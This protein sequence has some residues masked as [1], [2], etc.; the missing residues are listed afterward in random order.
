LEIGNV[1]PSFQKRTVDIDLE[2]I[3][4]PVA[5]HANGSLGIIYLVTKFGYLHIF[6]L[7][8]GQIICRERLD[9]EVIFVT[10]PWEAT[11]G[12]I[13]I[14]RSGRVVGVSV[15]KEKISLNPAMAYTPKSEPEED[16]KNWQPPTSEEKSLKTNPDLPGIDEFSTKEKLPPN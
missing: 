12:F 9:S 14:N 5:L 11:G 15:D 8:T 13:G 6:S 7:E 16:I 10:C 4:F 3:D 2:K 1:N